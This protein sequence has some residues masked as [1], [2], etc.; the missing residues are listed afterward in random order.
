MNEYDTTLKRILTRPGSGLLQA[1]TGYGKLQWLNI[2]LPEVTNRQVDLLG[3]NEDGELFHIELQSSNEVDFVDRMGAYKFAIKNKCRRYP[4]QL[5]LYVGDRPPN[6]ATEIDVPDLAFRYHLVN[7]KDLDGEALLNS[8]DLSDNVIA[9]LTRLGNQAGIVRRIVRRI[10]E[11]PADERE[12]AFAELRILAG[13]RK[14][15]EEVLEEER[16]M[17]ITENILDN[18]LIWPYIEFG[19]NRGIQKGIEKGLSQG[20]AKGRLEMVLSLIE[21]RF[22]PASPQIQARLESLSADEI[23]TVGR[24]ILTAEKVEDL[25]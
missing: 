21:D 24:R 4:R 22:G 14:L 13:L 25:F 17:P 15:R 12:T 11:G 20:V 2:E 5:T 19:E 3:E 9:I 23:K 8:Q 16:N 10:R 6:M 1:L 7:I 18:Q